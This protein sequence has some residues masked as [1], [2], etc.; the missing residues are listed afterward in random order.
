MYLTKKTNQRGNIGLTQINSARVRSGDFEICSSGSSALLTVYQFDGRDW[1][2]LGHVWQD[3]RLSANQIRLQ[4]LYA[5]RAG[6]I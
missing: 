6:R 5:L 4:L 3:L 1:H 2:S